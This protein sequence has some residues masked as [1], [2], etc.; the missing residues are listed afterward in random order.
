MSWRPGIGLQTRDRK[1]DKC[2]YKEYGVTG[3]CVHD[4]R[5]W[6]TLW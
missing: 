1:D 6:L 4:A 5:L 3:R 2:T